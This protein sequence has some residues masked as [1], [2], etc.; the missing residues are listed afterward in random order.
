MQFSTVEDSKLSNASPSNQPV[1]YAT[2]VQAVL[3]ALVAIGWVTIPSDTVNTIASC[4]GGLL[5][6]GAAWLARRHVTPVAKVESLIGLAKTDAENAVKAV[7]SVEA[8]A[9]DSANSV[10]SLGSTVQPV[11]DNTAAAQTESDQSVP[12]AV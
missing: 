9:V 12:P 6:L 8:K 11:V 1:I 5:A 7:Q 2:G 10:Q 4:I 3:T